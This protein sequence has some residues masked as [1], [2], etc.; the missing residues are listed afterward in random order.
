MNTRGLRRWYTQD[1]IFIETRG[2]KRYFL[3]FQYYHW[4]KEDGIC[5]LQTTEE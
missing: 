3:V 5:D 2:C 4:M 1:L